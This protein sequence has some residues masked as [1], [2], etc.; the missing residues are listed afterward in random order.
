MI[1]TRVWAALAAVGVVMGCS[2]GTPTSIAV[3]DGAQFAKGGGGPPAVQKVDFTISDAGTG[4]TSD[5]KGG[6]PGTRCCR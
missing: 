3:L 1:R 4:L 2:D 5:R 6:V